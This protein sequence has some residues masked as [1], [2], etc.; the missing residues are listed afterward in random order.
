[1]GFERFRDSIVYDFSTRHGGVS[2]GVYESLN[3]SFSTGDERD[4]VMENYRIWCRSLGVDIA[5]T[6]LLSQA[7]TTNV[8]RVDETNC[9]QG[10]LRGRMQEV[11]GM[12][13][14]CKGVALVTYHADCVP[15]YFYDPV[16]EAI[17][18]AHAGWRGTVN[19]MAAVMIRKMGEEFGSVPADLYTRIGPCISQTYF[20]C[21]RD[22]VDAVIAMPLWGAQEGSP[23]P[24]YDRCLPEKI[25]YYNPDTGKYHVSLSRLNRAVM[26]Q[27]GVPAEHIDMA[28]ACTYEHEEL[29][30]SHRRMGSARGG[31]AA[32]LMLKE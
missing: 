3:L 14:N 6:V 24:G 18:M 1:M 31:Q 30:F 21:D 20:E 13:T 22:V 2:T 32:L 26:Q 28:D 12:I 16:R 8:V 29:F 19:S 7:H 17:G 25:C 4:A 27:A 23:V 11:D 9:G 15:L 5:K 10:L